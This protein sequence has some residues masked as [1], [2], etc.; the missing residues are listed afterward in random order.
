MCIW[1]AYQASLHGPQLNSPS[2][3]TAY[4]YNVAENFM[5]LHINTQDKCP[6]TKVIIENVV[7]GDFYGTVIE[8]WAGFWPV[9]ITE[10]TRSKVLRS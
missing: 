8:I 5:K 9:R 6:G 4:K 1:A 3:R 7:V 2:E 10:K